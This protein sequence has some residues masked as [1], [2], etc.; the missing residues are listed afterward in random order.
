MG[1]A[2]FA[3]IELLARMITVMHLIIMVTRFRLDA[4]LYEPAPCRAAGQKGRPRKQGPRK[5]TLHQI[6][7]DPSTPGTTLEMLNWYGE[8]QRSIEIVSDTA[9]WYHTGMPIVPLRWV[10]IRDP[11][12][13]FK[14]RALLCT[15]LLAQPR[16]IVEWFIQRWQRE[17]TRREVREHLGVETERQWS[18]LAIAR[19][20]PILFGLYSLVTLLAHALAKRG[21]VTPRTCA[22][23][24]KPSPTFSD[25]LAAV[26]HHLW[27][28]PGF[29]HIPFQCA[30]PKM[31]ALPV[32]PLC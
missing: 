22:W 4:A 2:R 8:A 26:R 29:L 20:T 1:D 31:P 16:Q 3:V 24:V 32:Q 25:A 30:H 7:L 21:K 23:Y 6:A 27:R 13:I 15:D 10:V 12:G 19:A 14:T 9:V 11:L 18:D 17:V 5:P 28:L